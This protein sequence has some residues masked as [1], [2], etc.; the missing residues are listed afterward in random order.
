MTTTATHTPFVSTPFGV[1][2]IE[3]CDAWRAFVR[4]EDGGRRWVLLEDCE[5]DVEQPSWYVL[6]DSRDVAGWVR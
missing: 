2:I 5:L 3:G 6:P 4:F 1:G